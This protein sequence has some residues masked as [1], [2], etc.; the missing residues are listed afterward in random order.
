[1]WAIWG[2]LRK[3]SLRGQALTLLGSRLELG[4]RLCTPCHT[5]TW[6]T[7][8][9]VAASDVGETESCYRELVPCW[10]WNRNHCL[11]SILWRR[12]SGNCVTSCIF[13]AAPFRPPAAATGKTV[14]RQVAITHGDPQAQSSTQ[15]AHGTHIYLHRALTDSQVIKPAAHTGPA[16]KWRKTETYRGCRLA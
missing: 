7:L 11:E 15:G 14:A 13:A 12:T 16:N 2:S 3:R 9:P 10:P 1:M 8:S 6:S 4:M 5:G